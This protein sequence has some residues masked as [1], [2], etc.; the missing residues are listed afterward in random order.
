L[1]TEDEFSDDP[2]D[3]LENSFDDEIYSDQLV[4]KRDYSI[5]EI[6]DTEKR[7]FNQLSAI[8]DQFLKPLNKVIDKSKIKS[9]FANIQDIHA[10]HENLLYE[11]ENISSQRFE[12]RTFSK[13]FIYKRD[14]LFIYAEYLVNTDHAKVILEEIIQN[15]RL[16]GA[17][18]S[19]GLDFWKSQYPDM[20]LELKEL[21]LL[22]MQ[23]V[24]RYP[25]IIENLIK[26]SG[27]NHPDHNQLL[28]ALDGMRDLNMHINQTK[29][30]M[31]DTIKPLQ[32]L[33]KLIGNSKMKNIFPPIDSL[34][35]LICY[36]KAYKWGTAV[37]V[38]TVSRQE[39]CD[40]D[41]IDGI[42]VMVLTN[43]LIAFKL[44]LVNRKN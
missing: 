31:E 20:P 33:E 34:G 19:Q 27:K 14:A 9:I 23:R 30:D 25:L 5:K 17:I 22:P 8:I 39:S 44:Q 12:T 24:L 29:A 4:T 32:K 10:V 16:A 1:R 2:E 11:L 7:Y 42:H 37:N 21:L 41:A 18:V 3:V 15:N 26:C 35:K 43:F 38:N 28:A 36:S 13:P 40:R 6:V